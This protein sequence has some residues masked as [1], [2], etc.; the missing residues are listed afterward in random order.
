MK[1]LLMIAYHF[2]PLAGSSGIQRSLR[3]AQQLPSHGWQPAVLSVNSRAYEQT[4]SDLL[5]EL[6]ADLE[7]VRAFALDASRHLAIAGRYPGWLARPDR[8]LSWLLGAV[9]AG[10][11]MIR[12][13]RPAA[14]WS[15]YPIASAHLLGYNLAR[16]SGLPWVAD[17]RDPM[18]HDGYPADA[19]TWQ[20]FLRVEKKVFSRA[21]RA[22]FST[23]GAARLYRQRYPM[24]AEHIRVIEN[25]YDEDAF[26]RASDLPHGAALNPGSLTL[27]HSGIVYPQWRNPTGLFEALQRL[28]SAGAIRP[29]TLRL[30]F[31]APVHDR[32][33]ADLAERHGLG[34]MVEILPPLSYIEA[35]AEMLAAD[36]LLALQSADC[37]DQVPAKVYEYLR[38]R[39]AILGLADPQG[40]TAG[41]LRAAA[42][43]PI[44]ALEAP[45]EQIAGALQ[46]LLADLDSG[47]SPVVNNSMVEAASREARTAALAGLLNEMTATAGSP[48]S[49]T[50]N[51]SK[52]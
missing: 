22:V 47:A 48:R 36:A 50:P 16:L 10:L 38:A 46:A 27:L 33:L 32:W 11:A 8:W 20:S 49:L 45:A 44:C 26:Q 21:C 2:P 40:D 17:F 42:M 51:T 14:I 7:V 28:L 13:H 19:R 12:R 31:R 25:G 35:L 18:A 29:E 24:Q 1:R 43:G 4:G 5:A 34:F 52:P 3:F 23:P 41:I 37:N 39:K 6:P 30:R 9:P 15:T